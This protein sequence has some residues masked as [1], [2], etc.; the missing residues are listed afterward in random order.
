MNDKTLIIFSKRFCNTFYCT[1]CI[2]YSK[3]FHFKC[4]NLKNEKLHFILITTINHKNLSFRV[5]LY[6]RHDRKKTQF[7]IITPSHLRPHLLP[8][9]ALCFLSPPPLYP[10]GPFTLPLPCHH[11]SLHTFSPPGPSLP[12]YHLVSTFPYSLPANKGRGAGGGAKL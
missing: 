4:N 3:M 12:P 7:I 5:S 8:P 2:Q 1:D 10:L 11:P 6:V 9:L